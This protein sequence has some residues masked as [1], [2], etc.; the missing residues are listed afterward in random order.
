MSNNAGDAPVVRIINGTTLPVGGLTIAT[1]LPMY[2]KGNYNSTA[3]K[4]SA[5]MCDALTL[6]SPSWN[7]SHSNLSMTA[8][9]VASNMTVFACIM[10]GH[11]NTV[12]STYSGGLENEFRFLENWSGKNL[13]YLGSIIDLWFSRSATAP[14]QQTGYYYNAPNRIWSYDTDLVNPSNWP[15]GAPRVHTV[16]RGTWRQIS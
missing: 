13:T 10:T 3:K 8:N 9:R 15:P 14:W 6:L 1:D 2:I 16:Q 11:V 4:G 7:D 5:L 12:G